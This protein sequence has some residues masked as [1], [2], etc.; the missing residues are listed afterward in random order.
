MAN[1]QRLGGSYRSF[2]QQGC[3]KS[4]QTFSPIASVTRG[5]LSIDQESRN[6]AHSMAHTGL[7]SAAAHRPQVICQLTN[8]RHSRCAMRLP[9]S[10][11]EAVAQRL[12][13]RRGAGRAQLWHTAAAS[14]GAATD[15]PEWLRRGTCQLLLQR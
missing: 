14:G 7:V 11:P 4:L 3:T 1:A 13:R 8:L 2:R 10:Q 15:K 6:S 12:L 9:P 5:R